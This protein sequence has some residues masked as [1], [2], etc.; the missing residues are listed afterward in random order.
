[1]GFRIGIDVGG[2][3]TD[4]LLTGRRGRSA[5][6]KELSTP[7]DPS[8]AVMAG[9]GTLAAGE[10]MP[11]ERFLDGVELIVHGTTVTTNAV[12]TGSTARTG[13]I[14]TRGFRDALQMRRGLMNE[15][16]V[17]RF[18]RDSY[19]PIIGGGTSDIMRLIV[20][21]QLGL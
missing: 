20:A 7:A 3:F 18:L 1:M 16:L 10:A 6:H 21:R 2:T 11:L 19:F 15:F 14:T 13:L 12:L 17:Q 4:F 5:V 9:L 8:V